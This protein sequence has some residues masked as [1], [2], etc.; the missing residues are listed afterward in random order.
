MVVGTSAKMQ[1]SRSLQPVPVLQ[2]DYHKGLYFV[3]ETEILEVVN[4]NLTDSL[5]GNKISEVSIKQIEEDIL[6][7]PFVKSVDVYTGSN[8]KLLIDVAQ[9]EPVIRIIN[10]VGVS[11]YLDNSGEKI[12][13]TSNFTS[14]VP[15][16]TGYISDN[17]FDR[18]PAEHDH[19]KDLYKLVMAL[20][21]DDFFISLIDQIYR[22]ENGEW[23]LIPK[24][25]RHKI[26]IGKTE[27]LDDKLFRLKRFYRQGLKQAGWQNY[28][29]IDLRFKD[30]IICQKP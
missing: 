2:I 25:E 3:Q 8:G 7:I 18:G 19:L 16:A 5:A 11:Y 12:P 22:D 9:R 4:N 17:G 23:V 15:V 10:R 30:Q 26:V 20:R 24:S 13:H 29:T 27:G 1:Y 28:K 6:A 14:R 21:N